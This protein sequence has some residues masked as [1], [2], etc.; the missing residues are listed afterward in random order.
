[1]ASS[2]STTFRVSDKTPEKHRYLNRNS[3]THQEQIQRLPHYRGNKCKEILQ[4]SNF[5]QSTLFSD[6]GFVQTVVDCYNCH[7]NL[8]I[9]PDDVWAAIM[10]QFSFYI[11]KHAEE[12]R[13]KFVDFEGKRELT[14]SVVGTLRAAPYE[15]LVKLMSKEI[16]RNLIDPE[17]KK[18]ILPNFS[19]TT[20]ND[21][22]TVGVVFM[23]SMKKYFDYKFC[24]CCGIPS[25]TLEGT[26]DDW[27][28]VHRRLEKL[29]EYKLEKWHSML[30]PILKEFVDAKEGKANVDFW[31]KICHH[32]SGGSGPMYVSGWITA[33]CVFNKEGNWQETNLSRNFSEDMDES[34][35]NWLRLDSNDIPTG[36]VEVDVKIDDNGTEYDSIM[37]AGHMGAEI[38][39]DGCTVQPVL[40]WSIALKPTEAELAAMKDEDFY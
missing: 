10:T 20:D 5:P 40:G 33:F 6:N 23:A 27:K 35:V 25:I 22:V 24:L 15:T 14:V 8:V 11:N 4:T 17:V 34:E 38:K 2:T 36:I 12:F 37:F 31:Q 30:E 28:E 16:D 26:V 19:T 7:Y 21:L 32:E 39:K 9:R 1:M 13:G 29:K 18:W 3:Q